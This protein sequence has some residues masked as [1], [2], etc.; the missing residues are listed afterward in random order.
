MP[1][2]H[3]QACAPL[4]APMQ[5]HL[6]CP[7]SCMRGSCNSCSHLADTTVLLSALAGDNCRCGS[8]I[9]VD[10]HG[11]RHGFSNAIDDAAAAAT[12]P[13]PRPR[14]GTAGGRGPPSLPSPWLN[15]RLNT[16]QLVA[17][18]ASSA[19]RCAGTLRP[20]GVGVV[21]ADSSASASAAAGCV[22]S[23]HVE[24]SPLDALPLGWAKLP[25]SSVR[26]KF[27]PLAT[28]SCHWR[29]VLMST[30]IDD[31]RV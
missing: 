10:A 1:R 18:R 31:E 16:R 30:A 24:P 20:C 17:A 13:R 7:C 27:L 23:F 28:S 11:R 6:P 9:G 5:W 29:Q 19:G 15:R 4:S 26:D 3:A 8:T 22:A 14:V 12:T 21:I 25:W 2:K